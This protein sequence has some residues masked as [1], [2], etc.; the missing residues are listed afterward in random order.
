LHFPTCGM[1]LIAMGSS[2]SKFVLRNNVKVKQSQYRPWQAVR[3]P[4]G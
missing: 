1:K 2:I 3:V 4:G